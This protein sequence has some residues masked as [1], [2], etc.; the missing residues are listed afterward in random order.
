MICFRLLSP[1]HVGYRK[2][3]NLM[4]TRPYVPGK[5]LWAAL[6]ARLTRDRDSRP[7]PPC[8]S[9]Y[10]RIGK[11]VQ[12]YFRFGYLWPSLDGERPCFPWER[13]DFEYLFIGSYV[14]TALDYHRAAA[15]EG[16]LHEVEFISPYTRDEG[17]PVHLIG[18]LWVREGSSPEELGDW[19]KA[20]EKIQLGGERAYGWGRVR[21]L[22][23]T[24]KKFSQNRGITSAGAKWRADGDG[25]IVSFKGGDNLPAHAVATGHP[26]YKRFI[27]EL[28]ALTG[29]ERDNED[30]SRVWRLADVQILY[31][32]GSKVRGDLDLRV[33]PWG[34]LELVSR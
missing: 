31:V 24:L 20:L 6:T 27:G 11:L 5:L 4:Q 21:L 1:L 10:K 8:R 2:V 25:I 15:E 33:H 3:G 7:G 29:W 22:E 34:W 19:R 16:S 18:D 28:E 23:G 12:E 14:S 32:P 26:P 9:D 30:P 13:E 17:L